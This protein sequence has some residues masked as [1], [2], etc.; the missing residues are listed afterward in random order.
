ML[1]GV[2]CTGYMV[3]CTVEMTGIHSFNVCVWCS[4]EDNRCGRTSRQRPGKNDQSASISAQERSSCPVETSVCLA[5][6]Q[7]CWAHCS[8][9][10]CES[11]I[12]KISLLKTDALW[13]VARVHNKRVMMCQFSVL[14][15]V[16][17]VTC[18]EYQLSDD[19]FQIYYSINFTGRYGGY[20]RPRCVTLIQRKV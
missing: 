20:W 8:Q 5:L 15:C 2:L 7:T 4:T 17:G 6:P 3:V 13:I 14:R 18:L 11:E 12:N 1:V 19:H 9:Y 10:P 16:L